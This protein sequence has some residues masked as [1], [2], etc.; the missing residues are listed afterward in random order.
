[1]VEA[2]GD[3]ARGGMVPVNEGRGGETVTERQ[4][5]PSPCH[6]TVEMHMLSFT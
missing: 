3:P 4:V 6:Y 1:M 5:K 2:S